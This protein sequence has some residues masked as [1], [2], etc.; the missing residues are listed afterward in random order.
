VIPGKL[1]HNCGGSGKIKMRK[2]IKINIPA[3]VE[4]GGK[5]RLRGMGNPGT[6]GGQNGD[7]IVA[8]NVKKHQQFE[9]KGNDMYTKVIISYPQA[10]LGCKVN[11]KTLAK[12]VNLTI[13]PG[14]THGTLLRLKGLGLAVDGAQ[15]DQ[16]VEVNIDVPKNLTAKQKELLE[17][18]AKTM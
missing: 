13:P 17:E 3:G 2:K 16:Y 15:G 14:T 18:L 10:A 11:V 5:I 8:V 9:R 12:E 7:L 4:D 6:N 1:C